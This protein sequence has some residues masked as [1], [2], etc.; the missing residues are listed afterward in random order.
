MRPPGKK[1]SPSADRTVPSE[2]DATEVDTA[3][4]RK[5]M[6]EEQAR[7]LLDWV[8]TAG[9]EPV[10]EDIADVLSMSHEDVTAEALASCRTPEEA[11]ELRCALDGAPDEVLASK[12]AMREWLKRRAMGR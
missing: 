9:S 4:K 3:P 6:T 8:D 1:A 2:A 5:A 10:T 12:E 7:E 11:E